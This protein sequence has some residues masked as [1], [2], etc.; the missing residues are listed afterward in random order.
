MLPQRRQRLQMPANGGG[1]PPSRPLSLPPTSALRVSPAAPCVRDARTGRLRPRRRSCYGCSGAAWRFGRR[2]AP[3]A[4]AGRGASWSG[5]GERKAPA[6][7]GAKF[8]ETSCLVRS[9]SA[10]RAPGRA[11]TRKADAPTTAADA[12]DRARAR[13]H[14]Q[15]HVSSEAFD[16]CAFS[17]LQGAAAA[18]RASALACSGGRAAVCAPCAC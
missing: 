3:W 2:C 18:A 15:S 4:R 6:R 8:F 13:V 17:V 1:N 12:P 10:G 9:R 7:R 14:P 16:S 5:F 11:P